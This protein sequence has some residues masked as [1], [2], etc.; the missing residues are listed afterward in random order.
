M[1]AWQKMKLVIEFAD[2]LKNKGIS[3]ERALSLAEGKKREELLQRAA[4]LIEEMLKPKTHSITVDY[5]ISFREMAEKS[6]CDISGLSEEDLSLFAFYL[7][8]QGV[9]LRKTKLV[10]LGYPVSLEGVLTGIKKQKLIPA[11]PED[12]L[13]FCA[14]Y[15]DEEKVELFAPGIVVHGLAEQCMIGVYI[16]NDKRHLV[17]HKHKRE[18][19]FSPNAHF[20][21][22]I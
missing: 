12:L 19:H 9:Y 22:R 17:V 4:G 8:N 15:P 18:D 20:L 16:I 21:A 13:S 5:N 10:H 7:F 14:M 6:G 1:N 11:M 3:V 2:L